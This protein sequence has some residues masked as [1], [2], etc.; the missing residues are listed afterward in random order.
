MRHSLQCVIEELAH[1][2]PATAS[3]LSIDEMIGI[4]NSVGEE[5]KGKVINLELLSYNL[6]QS[7]NNLP[8]FLLR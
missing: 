8:Q 1:F 2:D 6:V 5:L 7:V 4:R 3:L